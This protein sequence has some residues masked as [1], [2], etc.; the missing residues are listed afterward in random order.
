M[1]GIRAGVKHLHSLKLVHNDINASNV[2]LTTSGDAIIVDFD[3]FWEVGDA[4]NG[5]NV[6]VDTDISLPENDE[7]SIIDLEKWLILSL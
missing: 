1:E 4:L 7:R 6:G 2:V 3:S 5:K